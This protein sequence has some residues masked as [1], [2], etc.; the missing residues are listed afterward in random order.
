MTSQAVTAPKI[1]SEAEPDHGSTMTQRLR[2]LLYRQELSVLME[3]HN[4]LSAKIVAQAG[5]AGVWA[6]SLTVSAALG[7]RD[8]NEASWTQVLE[9]LEFMSDATDV[10]ILMDG[11]TGYGNFNNVRR[12][13]TKLCQRGIAGV[14][15]EDKV[16]PKTNSLIGGNQ[17]LVSIGEF[18]GKIK[19]AKDSQRDSDFC[20]V[21]RIE[22]LIAGLGMDEAWKR[23]RA[24]QEAGA[25]AILLH[26]RRTDAREIFRFMEGW[27]GA[28]P[29][30][31]V[32]TTY[33][34]T[35]ISA[36]RKAGISTL[37]WANHTLR[38]SIAAM[39]RACDEI[40]RHSTPA[41]VIPEMAPIKDIFDL[42]GN[43]ELAEAEKQYLAPEVMKGSAVILAASRGSHLGELTQ[44][45]PKCMIDVR[46][47]PI[48]RHLINTFQ[49][50]GVSNV[51]VV[52]GY[53]PDRVDASPCSVF[54]NSDYGKNGEVASLACARTML[55]G[56]CLISYGDILFRRF[57][58]EAIQS[59][60][61]DIVLA[62]DG[63]AAAADYRDGARARDFV[64]AS[65]PFG[66]DYLQE[67]EPAQLRTIG[68]QLEPDQVS[69]EWMGLVAL[70][71]KGSRAVDAQ[72]D[73]MEKDGS[74]GQ[75]SMLD[76]FHA[77]IQ[78]GQ[79]ID[80][81]YFAGN[82]MDV[83][84]MADLAQARNFA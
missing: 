33:Y 48:L 54:I 81:V 22:A 62:V 61:G 26:S 31:I 12:L 1:Y 25:D 65:R 16:F 28:C 44:D 47:E 72:L 15:L 60:K 59:V 66:G 79:K 41:G 24:Y 11:D 13:V 7:V 49:K 29:V 78:K 36:Y 9:V 20:V 17:E 3:A 63:L 27:D 50:C 6:S 38:A 58:L 39:R 74:L 75:A 21:A 70:S 18:C 64:Q 76:L 80:V 73:C 56:P 5:F 40:H 83:D 55:D 37:I 32:P 35:P 30:V 46:G 53:R 57:I 4:G 23:A 51:G 19:A 10:P 84:D 71:A 52:C 45:Q 43:R 14:C 8:S 68:N 34:R 82:W 2:H 67:Q 77:M 42:V 69:G